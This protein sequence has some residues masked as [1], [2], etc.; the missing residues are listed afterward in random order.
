VEIAAMPSFTSPFRW[1]IIAQLS[2]AY[3]IHDIDLLD[4][5]FTDPASMSEA[6]WRMTLRY[7]NVWTPAVMRAAATHVGQTFLAFSRFPAAR[8]AVD[9]HGITT[10]RWTDMRFVGGVLALDQ[11]APGTG[12]F[13]A[14]VRIAPD[15][16][17]LE[18]L[19]GAR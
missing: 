12:L 3:E 6:P 13:T 18:E 5:A 2:N 4:T 16:T 14:T 1:R 7:P 9:S 19:L 10:V 17:I 15:G 11:P 8:S